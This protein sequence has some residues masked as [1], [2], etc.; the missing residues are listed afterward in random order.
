MADK[1]EKFVDYVVSV[2]RVT[3]VTKGGKRFEF[4]AL[5]VSGDQEGNVER[6]RGWRVHNGG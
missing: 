6:Y 5:V 3:K 2:R 4:S 1:K